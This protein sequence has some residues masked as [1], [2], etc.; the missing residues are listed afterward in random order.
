MFL[1]LAASLWA[2]DADPGSSA[3]FAVAARLRNEASLMQNR[4]LKQALLRQAAETFLQSAQ[5]DPAA[6]QPAALLQAAEC[7]HE[8]GGDEACAEAL[9][10]LFLLGRQ[11]P[12]HKL[13]GEALI[14]QG[15]IFAD[16]REWGRAVR[17]W[18]QAG[19]DFPGAASM[20]EA[21]FACGEI[22]EKQ[23]RNTEEAQKKYTKVITAYPRSAWAEKALMARAALY[24]NADDHEK[25]V[26]DYL[27]LVQNYRE[28][29]LADE[30]LYNAIVLCERRIKD[31][32]RAY[33]LCVRFKEQ[34][35]HSKYLKRVERT[36]SKTLR[37]AAE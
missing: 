14:L 9:K 5:A 2:A 12:R 22:F 21:T 35:A 27:A 31:Y 18:I 24:E 33:G 7:L 25:A 11:H 13:A 28:S 26:A 6:V 23:I 10:A 8:L 36:E 1:V 3:R 37:Y 20:P 32:K 17:A 34:F 29:E 4:S 15:K 19:E 30:A 16:N